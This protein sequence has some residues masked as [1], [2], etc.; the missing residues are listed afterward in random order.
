MSESARDVTLWF[1]TLQF[2]GKAKSCVKRVMVRD[3][4]FSKIA[5]IIPKNLH[6]SRIILSFT[7]IVKDVVICV[8]NRFSDCNPLL[9]TFFK[10]YLESIQI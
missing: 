4:S 9:A 3:G 10:S 2:V 7:F 8:S 6:T 1:P 5:A